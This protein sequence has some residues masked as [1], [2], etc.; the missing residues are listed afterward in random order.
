MSSLRFKNQGDEIDIFP[1]V[2]NSEVRPFLDCYAIGG[3]EKNIHRAK[4]AFS[5]Q[6]LKMENLGPA[7]FGD[8][9]ALIR[10]HEGI[11]QDAIRS[12][13]A[14]L[15][16]SKDIR[17]CT[18]VLYQAHAGSTFRP[19]VLT[20]EIIVRFKGNQTV[21]TKYN[22]MKGQGL[23]TIRGSEMIEDK[24]V[25][26]VKDTFGLEPLDTIQKIEKDTSVKSASP[27]VVPFAGIER[28]S[29]VP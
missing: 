18:P 9:L 2:P 19:M 8:S 4:S 6:V 7:G 27:N 20:D 10:F 28:L 16:T 3:E 23:H 5:K 24:F 12:K 17:F 26:R 13:I 1:G 14:D 11:E 21:R 25:A 29:F 22:A 15:L